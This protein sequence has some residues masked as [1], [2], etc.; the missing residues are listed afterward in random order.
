MRAIRPHIQQL[1]DEL[2]DKVQ[3]KGQMDVLSDLSYPLAQIV[4]CEMLGVEPEMR[5]TFKGWADS[6]VALLGSIEQSP[7]LLKQADRNS[8]ELY[9]Y[10]R[11]IADQHREHPRDNLISILVSAQEQGDRLNEDE[12]FATCATLLTGGYETTA[13]LI[14]NAMLTLIRNPEQMERLR[15]NPEAIASA[16]EELLRYDSPAQWGRRI[17]K[18]DITIGSTTICRGQTV[19]IGRAAANRDPAQF[20]DPDR[21]DIAR[22][23][24][25]HIAFGCGIHH[26]VGAELARIETSIAINSLLT[27]MKNFKL[28]TDSLTWRPNMHIRALTSLPLVFETSL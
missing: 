14:G 10:F 22:T 16:V 19:L 6:F 24:N 11:G 9:A 15:Q 26:C 1:V 5:D 27:R 23:P 8:R 12:L 13:N 21:L 20:V 2:L 28:A 18:E 7:N 25:N 4:I 17:A 3:N